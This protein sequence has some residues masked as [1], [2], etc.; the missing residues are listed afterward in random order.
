MLV[1]PVTVET[2]HRKLQQY[3]ERTGLQGRITLIPGLA[4]DDPLLRGAYHAADV[5]C[6]PSLH[7]PFGIVVLEAWAYQRPLITTLFRGAREIT[8]HGEDAYCVP[9]DD[10]AALADAL[11]LLIADTGLRRQLVE[12]GR[13]TLQRNFG[14]PMVMSQYEQLYR[15]LTVIGPA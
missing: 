15:H 9:C 8:T 5:F 13:A 14:E 12:G 4:A 2:Y 11:R 1:G 3:I 7:E 6:L 10:A